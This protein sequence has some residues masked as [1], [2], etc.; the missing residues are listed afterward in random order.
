MMYKKIS[1]YEDCFKV[2]VNGKY[3]FIDKR[4]KEICEINYDPKPRRGG[5]IE[6]YC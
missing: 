2:E 3:G 1:C 4:G 5:G 6:I